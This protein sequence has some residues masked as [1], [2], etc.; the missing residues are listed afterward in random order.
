MQGP[1]F[2]KIAEDYDGRVKVNMLFRCRVPAKFSAPFAV[3]SKMR[4]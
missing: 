1:V 3:F 4:R 2:E